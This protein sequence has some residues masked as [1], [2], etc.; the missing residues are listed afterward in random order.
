VHRVL[1]DGTGSFTR[2]V[3]DFLPSRVATADIRLTDVTADGR[4]D[5]VAFN[6]SNASVYVGLGTRDGVFDFSRIEQMLPQ[7]DWSQFILMT[8]DVNGDNLQDVLWINET[9]N[10]RVY[11]GLAR[12][13]DAL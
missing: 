7:D 1:S 3:Q 5:L 10:S 8:G 9:R 6:R 11:V 2:G 12:E 4:S 13:D